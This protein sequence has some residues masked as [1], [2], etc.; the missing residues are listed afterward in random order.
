MKRK[1]IKS[2]IGIA[3]VAIIAAFAYN[4]TFNSKHRDIASEKATVILS[5]VELNDAFTNNETLATSKYL[6]KVI[7]I[8]G[9]VTEVQ[10]EELTLDKGVHVTLLK[11]DKT[12]MST[13]KQIV[14]KGRCLGYDE[15]LE[16][17]KIDQA[18]IIN[19]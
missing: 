8:K 4:Y 3:V 18:T 9:K 5:A 11:G 1:V 10:M 6:D 19:E 14:I 7:E 12:D 15:L 17:V 2:L 13:H 16:V